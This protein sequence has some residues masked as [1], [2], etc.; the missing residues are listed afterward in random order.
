MPS[1]PIPNPK[2]KMPLKVIQ[3]IQNGG[4]HWGLPQ[5]SLLQQCVL[6]WDDLQDLLLFSALGAF[7]G[8]AWVDQPNPRL[9]P[10]ET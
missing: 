10:G 6:R 8:Q 9:S 7:G 2:P 4:L 5:G 3:A 1:H